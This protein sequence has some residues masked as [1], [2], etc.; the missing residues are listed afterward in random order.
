MRGTSHCWRGFNV[1]GLSK[2]Q[3]YATWNTIHARLTTL[4]LFSVRGRLLRADMIKVWKIFNGLSPIIPSDLFQ[5]VGDAR[6]RGHTFKIF[7]QR[8]SIELRKRFFSNRV[9]SLWNALPS[10]VVSA[11]TLP[12]FK[13]LLSAHLGE[14]LYEY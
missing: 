1:A 3:D 7:H 8:T 11:P 2:S 13:R 9:I 5:L 6:T 12:V 4:G 14:K 10:S